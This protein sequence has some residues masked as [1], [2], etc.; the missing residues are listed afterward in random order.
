MSSENENKALI[1]EIIEL[2][3]NP[4]FESPEVILLLGSSGA[5]KSSL[6]NTL[7]GVLTGRYYAIAKQ[8]SGETQSVTLDLLR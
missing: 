7:Y 6:V 5:G 1:D 4:D 2:L 8:G 3:N